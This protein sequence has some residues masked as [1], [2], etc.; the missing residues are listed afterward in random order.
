MVVKGFV[1]ENLA[2]DE[3][4]VA[5]NKKKKFAVLMP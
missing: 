1:T 3:L 5:M 2:A 4:S